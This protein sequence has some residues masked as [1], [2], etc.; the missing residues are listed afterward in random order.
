M[1]D[2]ITAAINTVVTTTP[3]VGGFVVFMTLYNPELRRQSTLSRGIGSALFGGVVAGIWE[4][5]VN[6]SDRVEIKIE[7]I[8]G[9]AAVGAAAGTVGIKVADMVF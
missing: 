6:S 9:T 5:T 8:L 3:W 4:S 2:G 1:M 7:K